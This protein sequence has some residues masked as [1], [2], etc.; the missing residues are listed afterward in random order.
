M[1]STE[2]VIRI[3][4]SHDAR[5]CCTL[6]IN[7]A[8]DQ[9]CKRLRFLFWETTATHRFFDSTPASRNLRP[10]S[11]RC[12]RMTGKG[13]GLAEPCV[14]L[15]MRC[16]GAGAACERRDPYMVVTRR[17]QRQGGARAHTI[18]CARR[19]RSFRA[20]AAQCVTTLAP[21]AA[22]AQLE[23]AGRSTVLLRRVK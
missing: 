8:H 2:L 19:R 20:A 22:P 4:P 5:M 10:F 14:L 17:A 3:Q 21:L 1:Q 12:L 7:K 23:G 16:C 9:H 18:G 6:R 11:M 13:G 15:P